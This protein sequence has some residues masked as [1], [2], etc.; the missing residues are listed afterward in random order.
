LLAA[1]DIQ[2]K[3]FSFDGPQKLGSGEQFKHKEDHI[4]AYKTDEVA[5]STVLLK[6]VSFRFPISNK[7]VLKEVSF[8]VLPGEKVAIVGPSGAGKSTLCDILL[9]L[10]DPT[11]GT[12]FIGAQPAAIWVDENPGKVSYLPQDITLTNG[13]LLENVCLGIEKSE[14]DWDAFLL[15]SRGAQLSELIQQLPDGIETIL[16]ADGT[17]LSGGQRQRI[18]LARALYSAPKILV[19]DEATSALDA[20]TEFEVMN[21]LDK[22]GFQTTVITIAHRLSSIRNFPRIIYLEDGLVLGDGSL[23]D[24][25]MKIPRFDNQ[26]LLSGI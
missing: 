22:L 17:L 16:G 26:L 11:S 6:R 13:T 23:T 20:E 25:R 9:G 8:Q 4:P 2:E 3:D 1:L 14:I 21:A 5:T 24:V 15:A 10:L 19:L 18:G 12:A 7:D